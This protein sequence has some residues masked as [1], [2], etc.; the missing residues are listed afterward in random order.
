LFDGSALQHVEGHD[1]LPIVRSNSVWVPAGFCATLSLITMV[2]GIVSVA[3]GAFSPSAAMIPFL[4]FLPMAFFMSGAND[5]QLQQR[6]SVLEKR[7]GEL[8][9][10]KPAESV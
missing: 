1:M 2:A 10:V 7:L 6:I 8:E 9:G 5:Q 3:V 4:S